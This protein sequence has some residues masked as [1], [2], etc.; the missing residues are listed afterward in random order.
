MKIQRRKKLGSGQ[1]NNK[2]NKSSTKI[3]F[4]TQ[5]YHCNAAFEEV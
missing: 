2:N 3:S 5:Y 4:E 1:N